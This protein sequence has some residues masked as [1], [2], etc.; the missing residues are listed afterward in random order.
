MGQEGD[1]GLF[2]YAGN[3]IGGNKT[4]PTALTTMGGPSDS[5]SSDE[6]FPTDSSAAF[7]ATSS[8]GVDPRLLP[9]E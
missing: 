2:F 8:V 6:T 7:L 3:V 4:H 1:I 5:V 9:A